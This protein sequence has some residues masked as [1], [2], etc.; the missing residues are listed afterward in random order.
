MDTARRMVLVASAA[1]LFVPVFMKSRTEQVT[2]DRAAFSVLSSGAVTVSMRG[3]V[4][5]PGIYAVPV[6]YLAIDAIKMAIPL[7]PLSREHSGP[8]AGRPIQNG[9]VVRL[10]FLA[11]GSHQLTVTG[12]TV[13]ERMVLKIPLEITTMN[14]DDFDRLP[15]VGP[16]LARRIVEY[17]QKNGGF[18][19]V[20]D[21]S[22]VEGVGAR[23]YE[24]LRAYFQP[25]V[26]TE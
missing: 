7:S 3:A 14:E 18:M 11:D 12:M 1:L 21:L 15:G 9:S 17:R 23:K 20:E 22:T 8:A 2:P 10:A 13:A 4:R 24:V 26:T 16:A 19:Q 6:N 25:Q 5:Y